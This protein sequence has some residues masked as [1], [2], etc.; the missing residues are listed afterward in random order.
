MGNFIIKPRGMFHDYTPAASSENGN[1]PA[2]NLYDYTHPARHFRSET[3]SSI[4]TVVCDLGASAEAIKG[5]FLNNVNFLD[6]WLQANETDSWETPSESD[7]FTVSRDNRVGRYKTFCDTGGWA[8]AYRYVRVYI[9]VQ[10]PTDGES[11]FRMDNVVLL[12]DA[13]PLVRN[14]VSYSFRVVKPVSRLEMLDGNVEKALRN[15][16]RQWA[17][18]T[19]FETADDSGLEDELYE[20]FG[21]TGDPVIFYE[22][23]WPLPGTQGAYLCHMSD[24]L[25]ISYQI[26]S[27]QARDIELLELI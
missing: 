4:V 14:P 27:L 19:A 11:F 2:T 16:R 8:G 1:Y 7:Q 18:Q 5:I 15:E 20:V 12:T 10:S 22:N 23:G 13:E 3:A 21:N 9:P 24:E 17:G 26:G 6:V 25:Q